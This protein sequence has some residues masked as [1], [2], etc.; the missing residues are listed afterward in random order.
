M[1]CDDMNIKDKQMAY[2]Q[3]V[4]LCGVGIGDG[5]ACGKLYFLRSG[6]PD[7]ASRPCQSAADGRG[8]EAVSVPSASSGQQTEPDTELSRLSHART[9]AKA[10]IEA[11][12][13]KAETEIG[14]EEAQIFDIH[15]MLLE[16]EDFS[17]TMDRHVADGMSAEEAVRRAVEQFT[18]MMRGL[19]DPYL[20]ARATDMQDIGARLLRILSGESVR[21]DAGEMLTDEPCILV[22]DD[23]T[24]SETVTL[25]RKK[26]LGF[27]TFTGTVNSHTA[28]LARAMG[29]PA[30]VG[31]GPIDPSC[32]GKTALLDAREGTLLI[33]PDTKTHTDFLDS[34]KEQRE[35][36]RSKEVYWRSLLGTPAK[37]RSG[38]TVLVYANIGSPEEVS[39]ALADGAEGI[40]L[41]RSEFL[42]LSMEDYP[43]EEALFSAYRRVAQEMA[44][45]RVVIRTVDIGADKRIPYFGLH[46]EENPAMGYRGVRICLDREELFKTQLRA[47][48]R[49]SAYG[50]VAVMI[51]MVVS[52]EEV[53]RC[54]QLLDVCRAELVREGKDVAERMEFGIMV[55]TPAAAVMSRELA[56]EVDFFSV[57]TNDLSQYTLAADRQN[58]A[59]MHIC[60]DNI[61]PVLRLAHMAARAIH[62]R[63][64]WIGVC[65]E[66]AADPA[67]TQ[68]WVDMQID[69]LSVSPPYLL[70]LR[71]S[72]T[73]C[74]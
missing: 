72:I 57:G 6:H 47:L 42:Y 68:R 20:S 39:A 38:H 10:Q 34:M 7:T 59:V 14:A 16:D 21:S 65:G 17:E 31:T 69:E 27:V 23:L 2:G 73:A 18:A 15:G 71:G 55:E 37:T 13:R 32:A 58:P 63:G 70:G 33:D 1:V 67:L 3:G 56:A 46:P 45:R 51:P 52:V 12:R 64:G 11:M 28:I 24:P 49:A 26:I 74:D 8:G 9:E 40:G 41:L 53:R 5:K 19:N 50:R 62:E 30:L 35:A 54:R 25:D 44:G 22:A 60:Q 4:R 61:E 36:G 48:L 66:L 43:G 29:I